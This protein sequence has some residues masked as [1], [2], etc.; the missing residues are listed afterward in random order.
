MEDYGH[1]QLHAHT[2]THIPPLTK[3]GVSLTE[4]SRFPVAWCAPVVDIVVAVSGC[5][6]IH[7]LEKGMLS[8]E[9]NATCV[10]CTAELIS[11]IASG[12]FFVF[13]LCCLGCKEA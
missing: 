8:S 1:L 13:V 2:H 12:R 6:C 9:V 10:N 7:S 3:G 11:K 4:N 5:M